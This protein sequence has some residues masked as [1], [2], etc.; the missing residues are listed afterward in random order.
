MNILPPSLLQSD[1]SCVIML[2]KTIIK[3]DNNLIVVRT[4][5]CRKPN[6]GFIFFNS[7]NSMTYHDFFHDICRQLFHDLNFNYY[8]LSFL[9]ILKSETT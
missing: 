5:K 7:S 4:W 9:K 3:T 8:N 2:V 6:A 1:C